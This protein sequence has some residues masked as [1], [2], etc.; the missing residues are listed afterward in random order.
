MKKTTILLLLAVIIIG[1]IV[2]VSTVCSEK[3]KAINQLET[4][5]K[6]VQKNGN[7]YGISEWKDVFHQ[8]QSINDVIDKHYGEY[9]QKQ[10]NRINH[11]K[12]TIKQAAWD[13]LTS[14]FELIP[15]P[16]KR[17]ILDWYNSLFGNSAETTDVTE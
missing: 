12:S 9:S 15:E 16:I 8:Y 14:K 3:A 10:R 1:G 11:A 5:A 7:T 6:D 17:P 2:L 13:S 4:L